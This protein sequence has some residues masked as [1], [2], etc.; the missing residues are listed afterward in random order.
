MFG[1]SYRVTGTFIHYHVE[2]SER[3]EGR[4]I[5]PRTEVSVTPGHY[6]LRVSFCIFRFLTKTDGF[7][8]EIYILC[9]S[10]L[11]I[12][13]GGRGKYHNP[14]TV[15][16]PIPKGMTQLLSQFRDARS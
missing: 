5:I 7:D 11:P 2:G 4:K 8:G 6:S 14:T 13:K 10:V 12:P 3:G 15:P 1:C 16:P 9:L